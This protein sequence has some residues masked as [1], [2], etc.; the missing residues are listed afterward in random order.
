MTSSVTTT[1]N[2]VRTTEV[3]RTLREGQIKI[4]KFIYKSVHVQAALIIH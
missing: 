1:S 2:T 4:E 3:D